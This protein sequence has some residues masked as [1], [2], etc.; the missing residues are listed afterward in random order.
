[1]SFL[2][3]LLSLYL[4]GNTD[5]FTSEFSLQCLPHPGH[6]NLDFTLIP[7]SHEVTSSSAFCLSQLSNQ[8]A[9]F[10]HQPAVYSPSSFWD[11]TLPVGTFL[12]QGEVQAKMCLAGLPCSQ[13]ILSPSLL[14]SSIS[15]IEVCFL[16]LVCSLKGQG[17]KSRLE[18]S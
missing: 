12:P 17:S 14:I 1:M 18:S 2:S 13:L 11:A 9:T 4:C 5:H 16:F 10:L 7:P 6:W 8:L 3:L 15:S